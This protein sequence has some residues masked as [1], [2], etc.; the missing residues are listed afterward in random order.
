MEEKTGVYLV[1]FV[2]LYINRSCK[3]NQILVIFL[4]IFSYEKLLSGLELSFTY[5]LISI[6]FYMT[7]IS[8]LIY[9]FCFLFYTH[10]FYIQ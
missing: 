10:Q 6:N 3:Y 5:L 1:F 7:Y 4:F 2:L 9:D 8:F